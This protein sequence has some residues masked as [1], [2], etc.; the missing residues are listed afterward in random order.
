MVSGIVEMAGGVSW[1]LKLGVIVGT[2][3]EVVDTGAAAVFYLLGVLL[4]VLGALLV[5][6][7]LTAGRGIPVR[8]AGAIVGILA[9][10]ASFAVLDAIGQGIVGQR[11][12][13]YAADESGIFLTAVIWLAIGVLVW[14]RS[15]RAPNPAAARS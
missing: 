14:S 7:W 5:G 11:G 12:P 15:R 8:A 4:L 3:G 2:G 6:L 13:N 10:F 9:F 1:L